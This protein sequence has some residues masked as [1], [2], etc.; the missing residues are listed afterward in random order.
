MITTSPQPRIEVTPELEP[1]KKLLD[2]MLPE[3]ISPPAMIR[4]VR[5]RKSDGLQ[6]PAIKVAG[7]WYSTREA[8]QWYLEARTAADLQS[9][10]QRDTEAIDATDDELADVGL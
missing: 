5:P 3:P 9:T 7:R 1:L 4:W 10:Q 6:L 2:D 8:V